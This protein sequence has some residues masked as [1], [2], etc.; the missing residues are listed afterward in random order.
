[1]KEINKDRLFYEQSGGGVTFSGGEPFYQ[2][3][4]LLEA[5]E[6][7]KTDYINTAI[8]TSGFCDSDSILK[9]AETANYFLYDIKFMDNVKHEKYCGVPNDIVLENLKQ[10]SETKTKLLLR[11]P[12]IPTIND[13]IP[14]MTAIFRFVKDFNNIETVHLLPYHNIQADKYIKIGKLYKLQEISSDESP[15]M[16]EIKNLFAA[17]FKTKIGG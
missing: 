9:A 6:S 14:E 10:L 2:G 13:D 7:C 11:I 17:K 12:V 8:D 15:N 4:F 3:K 5:L 16:E 1:M